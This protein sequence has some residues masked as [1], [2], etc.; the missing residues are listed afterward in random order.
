MCKR[1]CVRPKGYYAPKN[2][3]G[4]DTAE[5]AKLSAMKAICFIHFIHQVDSTDDSAHFY[6]TI[7]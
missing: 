1:I 4:N 7:E 3:N 2:G 5:N 6:A